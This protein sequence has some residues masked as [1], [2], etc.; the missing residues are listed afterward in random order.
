[1]EVTHLF[2]CAYSKGR[3]LYVDGSL[4]TRRWV[5]SDGQERYTTEVLLSKYRGELVLLESPEDKHGGSTARRGVSAEVSAEIPSSGGVSSNEGA[6]T[7][8][9][10]NQQHLGMSNAP[11][12]SAARS[13]TTMGIRPHAC[14]Q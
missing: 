11:H 6:S 5:A 9:F 8:K 12:A 14:W 1:M 13:T 3:R 7:G 4:Q 10:S 2:T